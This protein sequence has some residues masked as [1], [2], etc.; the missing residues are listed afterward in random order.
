MSDAAQPDPYAKAIDT[1]Y[2]RL[3]V[4]RTGTFPLRWTISQ[5]TRARQAGPVICYAQSIPG[6]PV[7]KVT[8]YADQQRTTPI[9]SYRARYPL[10]TKNTFDVVDLT[11]GPLGYFTKGLGKSFHNGEFTFKTAGLEGVGKDIQLMENRFK[12]ILDYGGQVDF[13]FVLPN[14]KEV[15][16]VRQGWGEHDPF[17]VEISQL[18]DGRQMDWRMA[19]AMTVGM[20]AML[21]HMRG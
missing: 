16:A 20:D 14:I 21:N 8:F 18:P 19:A 9:F 6:M 2:N 11:D 17:L 13:R 5:A 15:L 12:R 10:L 3:H 7:R 1:R 4:Q